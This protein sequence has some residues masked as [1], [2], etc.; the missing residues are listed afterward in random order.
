MG[1]LKLTDMKPAAQGC[2]QLYLNLQGSLAQHLAAFG[3]A[4][5]QGPLRVPP[6]P[7]QPPVGSSA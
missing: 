2:Q 3:Q 7:Q 6:E 5:S 1:V 4:A